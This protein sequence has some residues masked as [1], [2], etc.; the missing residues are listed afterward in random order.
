VTGFVTR[1]GAKLMLDGQPFVIRGFNVYNA[2]SRGNCWYNLG[3]TDGALDKVLADA[4]GNTIRAWFFQKLATTNGVRD[5]AA[6]D[7][8]LAVCAARGIRVVATLA[9]QWGDC[10]NVSGSPIYKDEVWYK[11]VYTAREAGMLVSYRD[12]VREV[13]TRYRDNPT[14]LA[15]QLM[16][17]AEAPMS[18]TVEQTFRAW[19][20][21]MGSVVKAADTNHL[22]NL[23]SMSS[24]QGGTSSGTNYQD[25]LAIPTFDL[26]EYHD[27][28]HPFEA[29]PGDQWNGLAARLAQATALGKPLFVGEVGI[30]LAD[31]AGDKAKRASLLSA[32]ISAQRAAGV[33]GHLVWDWRDPAQASGEDYEITVGDPVVAVVGAAA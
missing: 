8:T 20:I 32:K 10:E 14:I 27:Y 24:G 2:N 21:D 22:L 19:A 4:G 29:M 30:H 28:G 16:N 5:W 23:G 33:V 26:A 25:L 17:E 15:W 11:T 13:V 3:F 12:W 7:H 1:S 6:F 9:N 18:S 31:T